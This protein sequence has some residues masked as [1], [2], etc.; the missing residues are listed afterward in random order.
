M[1]IKDETMLR[2]K[3]QKMFVDMTREYK[4]YV[5][6]YIVGTVKNG[7]IKG[8]DLSPGHHLIHLE[9]DWCRSKKISVDFT[10]NDH[11]TLHAGNSMRWFIFPFLYFLKLSIF[12]NSYLYLKAE[13][14]IIS[15]I[16][17]KYNPKLATTMY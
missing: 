2:I 14:E 7:E 17:M 16:E 5:D 8:F 6:G 9:I 4:V 10:G 3:R 13:H 15:K 1:T 12:R 11:I